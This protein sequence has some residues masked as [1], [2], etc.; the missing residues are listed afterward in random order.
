MA[1]NSSSAGTASR[2]DGSRRVRSAKATLTRVGPAAARGTGVPKP[3]ATSCRA[4]RCRRP[5]AGRSR[6]PRRRGCQSEHDPERPAVG[7]DD[8]AQADAEHTGARVSSAEPTSIPIRWAAVP[9]LPEGAGLSV[10]TLAGLASGSPATSSQQ[11]P[12]GASRIASL[13]CVGGHRAATRG[14]RLGRE[15]RASGPARRLL[16][17][18][19]LDGRGSP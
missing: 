3:K 11:L 16:I 13:R 17:R 19:V 12:S 8:R 7:W 1:G 4:S 5:T 2:V 15:E 6:R 10:S 9:G 18:P 14:L